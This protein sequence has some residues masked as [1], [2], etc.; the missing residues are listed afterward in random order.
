MPFLDARFWPLS[1][2]VPGSM[3]SRIVLV[4]F[5]SNDGNKSEIYLQ[6]TAIDKVANVT[7]GKRY[8]SKK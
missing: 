5:E 2:N 6:K 1:R 8:T 4:Y 3:V 7:K